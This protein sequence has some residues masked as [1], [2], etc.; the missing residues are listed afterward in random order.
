MHIAIV[1]GSVVSSDKDPAY[2]GRTLLLVSRTGPGGGAPVG[3]VTVAVDYVGAGPGDTVLV[4]A[5]PGLASA[6]FGTPRAPMRELIM[7][8][9]D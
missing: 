2:E 4:G 9:I 6:V 1:T 7:G 3:P 8:I 5:A